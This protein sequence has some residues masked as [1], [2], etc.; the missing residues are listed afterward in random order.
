MSLERPE[1]LLR[2]PL[3]RL[4]RL[5]FSRVLLGL[6]TLAASPRNFHGF[7]NGRENTNSKNVAGQP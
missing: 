4:G 7:E 2:G 3:L 6:V 1:P 5:G